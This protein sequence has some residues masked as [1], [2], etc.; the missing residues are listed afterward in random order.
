[1]DFWSPLARKKPEIHF[2]TA[3][4]GLSGQKSIAGKRTQ[5]HVVLG[6]FGC[7]PKFSKCPYAKKNIIVT[8]FSFEDRNRSGETMFFEHVNFLQNGP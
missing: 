7:F 1:V 2:S 5:K 6:V 4:A 8:A 3:E